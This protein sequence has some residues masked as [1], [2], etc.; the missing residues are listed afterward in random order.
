MWAQDFSSLD[1]NIGKSSHLR[2]INLLPRMSI[3][4]YAMSAISL[5][6]PTLDVA[7][8]SEER[9]RA[10]LERKLSATSS[11]LRAFT[12]WL[13]SGA[14]AGSSRQHSR[15][16]QPRG[17]LEGLCEELESQLKLLG[18]ASKLENVGDKA[19]FEETRGNLLVLWNEYQRHAFV[20]VDA[21]RK[22]KTMWPSLDDWSSTTWA[23]SRFRN[24]TRH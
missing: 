3:I 15:L 18:R 6:L 17:A 1:N 22:S 9:N 10:K 19:L 20:L 24:G 13:L 2:S 7:S 23:K 21:K 12:G 11:R 14:D 16:G 8:D 4:P 5:D